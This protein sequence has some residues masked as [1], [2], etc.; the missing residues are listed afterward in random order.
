MMNISRTEEKWVN[1]GR[2]GKGE[3]MVGA[4]YLKLC[5]AKHKNQT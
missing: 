2:T 5:N 4:S 1:R 3:E